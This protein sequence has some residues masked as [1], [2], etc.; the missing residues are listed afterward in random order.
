LEEQGKAGK[1]NRLLALS[2]CKEQNMRGS[3][4]K[5]QTGSSQNSWKYKQNHSFSSKKRQSPRPLHGLQKGGGGG[6]K[7]T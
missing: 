4:T 2:L 5:H 3:L 7:F 6:G 1:S